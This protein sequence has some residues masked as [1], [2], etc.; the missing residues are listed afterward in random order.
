MFRNFCRRKAYYKKWLKG[1][2][3][4]SDPIGSCL[5]FMK[6]LYL[7]KWHI[8]SLLYWMWIVYRNKFVLSKRFHNTL[9]YTI[10]FQS[11][12]FESFKRNKCLLK[13][14]ANTVFSYIG[15]TNCPLKEHFLGP[16]WTLNI[17]LN[18]LHL[19]RIKFKHKP[20][21]LLQSQLLIL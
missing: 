15:H 14:D 12:G 20:F 2:S 9:I 10:L 13:T 4:H 5:L 18:W 6:I 17:V 11:H 19:H 21:P 8:G 16:K 3:D 1:Q 7:T